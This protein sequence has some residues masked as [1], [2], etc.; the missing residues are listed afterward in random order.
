MTKNELK[1]L[2][3]VA[4]EAQVRVI[5]RELMETQSTCYVPS[6]PEYQ[7]MNKALDALFAMRD[8]TYELLRIYGLHHL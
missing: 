1:K 7:R 2:R 4:T 5:E 6:D 3:H 8:A